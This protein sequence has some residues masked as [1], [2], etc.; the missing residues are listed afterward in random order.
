MMVG[1][2]HHGAWHC[3][4][5]RRLA[6]ASAFLK[7]DV[8]QLQAARRKTSASWQPDSSMGSKHTQLFRFH[9]CGAPV[10][11]LTKGDGLRESRGVVRGRE[12]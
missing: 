2:L 5:D 7:S 8:R 1:Q 9:G 4:S 11:L 6:D 3:G 10:E 12:W